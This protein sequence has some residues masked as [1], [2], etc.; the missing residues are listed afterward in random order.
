MFIELAKLMQQPLIDYNHYLSV[1]TPVGTV[2]CV[3]YATLILKWDVYFRS[4]HIMTFL[5]TVGSDGGPLSAGVKQ[6]HVLLRQTLYILTCTYTN[7]K[8]I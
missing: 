8:L 6:N 5:Q 4:D 1:S 2:Q 3:L 7:A